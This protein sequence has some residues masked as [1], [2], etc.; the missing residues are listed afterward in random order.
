MIGLSG[1]KMRLS[2][3]GAVLAGLAVCC[4]SL[5]AEPA[6]QKPNVILVICDDL[7]RQAM[8]CYGG[9]LM[10]TPQMD[11][12]AKEGARFDKGFVSNSI[13]G[14]SRAAIL[15]G[16][17]SHL[18]GFRHNRENF[19]GAQQTFPKL[20]QAA[21]YETAVIGK[22]HLHSDP[23]GFDFWQVLPG[24]GAYWNPQFLTPQGKITR[25]GYATTVITD[26]AI[27]WLRE[28]QHPERPFYLQIGHKAPHAG[29]EPDRKFESL[30]ADT[31]LPEPPSLHEDLSS[32]APVLQKSMNRVGAEMWEG[33]KSFSNRHAA[34]PEGLSERELR[35]WV[36]QRYI[37]DYLR[38]VASVDENIGRLLDYLDESGLADDALFLFTS[39]QG[40]FLGEHGFYDK[41]LMYEE[42]QSTPLLVR[43]SGAIEA[44]SV[45]DELVLNLDFSSTIL[46]F[47]GVPVP[48]DMQG[49]SF[50]PLVDPTQPQVE[51]RDAVY[52]RY[53][54]PAYGMTP[55]EG[56]RTGRYKL[57]RF[58]GPVVQWELYDLSVDP[59]ET[60]N[61]YAKASPELIQTLVKRL[62]QLRRQY[63]VPPDN[64]DLLYNLG[65]KIPPL[66]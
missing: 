33:Q 23:T 21:G 63:G 13:C 48:T 53:Y 52:Y 62:E 41:R 37:K 1:N 28:R 50:R 65:P 51:W 36:Y 15:T 22:W 57:I 58:L 20:L 24:Q 3:A 29:W 25:P 38:C 10:P 66:Q 46:D 19:D 30:F 5:A 61:I 12:L 45:V 11:R 2:R 59:T 34:P 55:H 49:M 43:C 7:T 9:K 18:N 32:H 44:G 4:G 54:D 8:G 56:V 16:K 35:S 14:P 27:Q 60:N 40:F 26:E 39:D 31:D 17:Y 47:A 6:V 64:S 42:T